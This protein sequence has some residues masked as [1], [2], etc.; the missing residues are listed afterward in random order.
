ML[1]PT[2]VILR[3]CPSFAQGLLNQGLHKLAAWQDWDQLAGAI[4]N[5]HT[6]NK[7]NETS[8]PKGGKCSKYPVAHQY[9]RQT[10]PADPTTR[11]TDTTVFFDMI[12]YSCL[13]G[14]S[15]GNIAASSKDLAMFFRDLFGQPRRGAILKPAT[16]AEMLRWQNLTN[17]WTAGYPEVGVWYGLATYRS[18]EFAYLTVP[19]T[20]DPASTVLYG[21]P[22]ADW[23]SLSSP[24]CGYN[25]AFGFG[26]CLVY[27]SAIGMN[28]TNTETFALSQNAGS[29]TS[30]LAYAA[31]L[32]LYGGPW[33]DC[34]EY[35]NLVSCQSPAVRSHTSNLGVQT[36]C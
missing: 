21:H 8:F 1:N 26:I 14:W 24:V 3:N 16:V 35:P 11:T 20:G 34:Y 23:G 15:M 31:V 4:P 17:D 5:E 10:H 27:N 32:Q 22:G 2:R 28:C 12:N 29:I 13:N 30:C 18:G 33:L 6:R 25:P 9:A 7:Y 19:G 36:T